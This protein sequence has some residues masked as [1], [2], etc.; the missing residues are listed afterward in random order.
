MVT[1]SHWSLARNFRNVKIKHVHS[2]KQRDVNIWV[3]VFKVN[4]FGIGDMDCFNLYDVLWI[5]HLTIHVTDFIEIDVHLDSS[6]RQLPK[7]YQR[8]K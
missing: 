2:E 8:E 7:I 4:V 1:V 6:V 5:I 3:V